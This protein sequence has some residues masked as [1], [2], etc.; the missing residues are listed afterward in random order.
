M[1][2]REV[3]QPTKAEPRLYYGYIVVAAAF[4]IM[5]VTWGASVSYGV[6]FKPM[7]AEF[8][9]TRAVTSGAFSL[10][11]L[12]QGLLAIM[13]GRLNDRFGP[14]IVATICGVVMG[15]GYLLVSQ[16]SAVWQLYLFYGVIIGVGM[17]GTLVPLL[18]TVVRWFT[19]RRSMMSGI[20]MMGQTTGALFGPAAANWLILTYDW[21]L[22]FL[23][24]GILVLVV[25]VLA[26]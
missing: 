19:K 7:L 18:S 8:G 5:A 1:Q 13:M 2:R 15:L 20:V 4:I 21:R 17:S 11:M 23:I 22:S 24:L 10:S 6:F 14:R 9:W 3:D 12:M 26:A 16:V 25:I